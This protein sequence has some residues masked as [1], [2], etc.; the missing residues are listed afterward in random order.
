MDIGVTVVVIHASVDVVD[1]KLEMV[2][3]R[4]GAGDED[5]DGEGR[6]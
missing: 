1:A 6:L 2:S 4:D 5:E 3:E